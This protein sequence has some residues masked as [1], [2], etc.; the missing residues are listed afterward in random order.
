MGVPTSQNSN[1]AEGLE[2]QLSIRIHRTPVELPPSTELEEYGG[3]YRGAKPVGRGGAGQ[4]HF[5]SIGPGLCAT[6]SPRVIFSVTMPY[7]G[8]LK[9]CMDFSPCDAFSSSDVLE[10]VNQQNSWNSLV[11]STYLLYLE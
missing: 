10:M 5:G 6:S 11:I 4:P 3:I 2:S 8:I 7:F 9:I 1:T